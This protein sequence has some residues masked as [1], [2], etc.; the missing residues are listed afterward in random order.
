[1]R[2]ILTS[3]TLPTII[4]FCAFQET[5]AAVWISVLSMPRSDEEVEV[6][7]EVVLISADFWACAVCEGV[8]DDILILDGKRVDCLAV[9]VRERKVEVRSVVPMGFERGIESRCLG[10]KGLQEI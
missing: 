9:G 3:K 7:L 10:K 4:F 6:E 1:M 5:P 8:L 2:G